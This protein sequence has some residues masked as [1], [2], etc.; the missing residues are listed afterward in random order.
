MV[1]KD[2]ELDN[3]SLADLVFEATVQI[4]EGMVS[5]YG[6]VAK[7]LGD[8]RASR[9]VGMILSSNP[10]PIVVPCHRVV[11][12]NGQVGWYSGKGKGAGTKTELLRK[13]G[14]DIKDGVI[15]DWDIPRFKDFH[16]RPVLREMADLQDRLA[17]MVRETGSPEFDKV[18][19]LDVSYEG[20]RAF[21]AA[22]IINLDGGMEVRTARTQVLFPYV[23]TYLG[24]RELPAY[25]PL[26]EGLDNSLIFIDGQGRLHPRGAG[27]ACQVGLRTGLPTIGAAKSLL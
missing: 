11:Y 4:P 3:V 12:S 14:L 23:P 16:V 13:E 26:L 22:A 6:D 21:A 1:S 27:I 24:F 7:A 5:T 18:V 10:R 9:V 15:R 19:G 8:V 20:D 2:S 17:A 25:V